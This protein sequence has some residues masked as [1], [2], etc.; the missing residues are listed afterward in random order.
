MTRGFR[1]IVEQHAEEAAF[2]WLLRSEATRAPNYDLS[3][4]SELDERIDAHLDGLRIAGARGWDACQ[5]QLLWREVGE[6]FVAAWMALTTRIGPRLDFVLEAAGDS[7]ELARGV[8]GALAWLPYSEI[9]RVVGSFLT[10]DNHIVRRIGLAA[11]AV[12][13]RDPGK[14]LAHAAIDSHPALRT[15][16]FRAAAELGRRDLLPLC[17]DDADASD[18]RFWSAWSAT[19]LGDSSTTATLR[20]GATSGGP[21]A[22]VACDLAAR[23]L[24]HV[25]ALAWRSD[26]ASV[27]GGRR[28]GVIV[29]RALGD[30][31]LVP[32]LIEDM[33]L[34]SLA[35]VAGE[36]FSS[37]TGIDLRR[38]GLAAMP[39]DGFESGP[40]DDPTDDNI[41][42]D[43]DEH[44][45]WPAPRGVARWWSRHH[46]T[47]DNGRRY[48]MGLPIGVETLTQVLVRGRQ[49]ERVAAALELV[50][51]EPGRT[52]FE[53]RGRAD[54][55]LKALASQHVLS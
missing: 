9:E 5:R 38:A 16:A 18:A 7:V 51:L 24:S 29:A 37:I 54:G 10:S 25:D 21:F 26:V 19:L 11:S 23:R 13:R 52:L 6:F 2:L 47:F 27:N 55:Q 46:G 39:P 30:P 50:L 31:A 35:R 28:L 42:M 34:E 4:L 33:Q 22:A 53:V 48:L 20:D 1:E 14:A 36:A 44:L 12:H 32:G 43:P 15:R 3:D 49:R 17:R 8:V 40:N 41:A 45:P